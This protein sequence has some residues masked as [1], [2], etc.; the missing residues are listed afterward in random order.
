MKKI[1]KVPLLIA[2]AVTLLCLAAFSAGAADAGL[3]SLSVSDFRQNGTAVSEKVVWFREPT[4]GRYYLFLPTGADTSALRVTFAADAAVTCDGQALSN[5]EVTDSLGEGEHTLQC[6]ENVYGLTVLVAGELPTIY[7]DTQ[8]GTLEKVHANKNYKEPGTAFILNSD[9]SVEYADEL[10]YIKGRGNSTWKSNDKKSYNI[11]LASK[12]DLFGL[13]KSKKWSLLANRSDASM[14]RN[15][16]AFSLGE[17]LGLPYV[18]ASEYFNF[19]V[20]GE[21]QGVYQLTEKVEIDE[22]RVDIF[23]L[24]DATEEVNEKDLEEYPLAGAQKS[25]EWDTYKY[26]DIP[27]DPEEI[28]GGYLLEL[29]KLYRY[30]EEASG[31][32]TERGQAVVIK[33]PEYATKKQASY[34]S[35]YYQEF[36]DALYAPDGYNQYGRHYSEYVDMDSFAEIYILLEF[37]QN[38]DGCSSS[39][40]LSK[41]VD[42]KLVFS[43][44]WDYDLG[45]GVHMPNDLIN[46]V[47]DVADPSIFY[48]RTCFIGNHNERAY[49]LLAQA[50]RHND[51]Q[52]RVSE[53]WEEKFG[54]CYEDLKSNIDSFSGLLQEPVYADSVRWNIFGTTDRETILSS[55]RAHVDAIRSFVDTRYQFLDA[56]MAKDT[57]FVKYDIGEY[58]AALV[59]DS[60][61]YKA[62]DRAVVKS[63]TPVNNVKYLLFLGW[64][65]TPDGNVKY[66]PGDEIEIT[67]NTVLYA[68]WSFDPDKNIAVQ[69]LIDLVNELFA[70]LSRLKSAA[71]TVTK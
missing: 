45:F 41:D 17:E 24:N 33:E 3:T 30:P 7:I 57:Y 16:L 49:G 22:K 36:E 27:N 13:G 47:P 53:I 71:L 59:N 70:R 1:L 31:F 39:F 42:G 35:S 34:I 67:G 14:I 4:G 60:T 54:G 21:Y 19:Y 10:D 5:G 28:E 20:N 68:R 9:G 26:A 40:F 52:E 25:M 38:F 37:T 55:H 11:K 51:F 58:G 48:I 43:P 64:A 2:V 8:S 50:F 15:T 65:D 32:V 29:E 66:Q 46:H 69:T 12:A 63:V 62:G 6:G 23:N 56:A 61:Q 44:P 18:M